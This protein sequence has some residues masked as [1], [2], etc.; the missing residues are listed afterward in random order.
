[1]PEKMKWGCGKMS[2][3]KKIDSYVKE[4]EGTLDVRKAISLFKLMKKTARNIS[5]F[6]VKMH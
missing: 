1:M 2:Q 5:S 4:I 6:G 3:E